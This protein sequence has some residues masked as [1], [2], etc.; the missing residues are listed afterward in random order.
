MTE[1]MAKKAMTDAHNGLLRY[2]QE[3]EQSA[4]KRQSKNYVLY[5]YT[6]AE[7]LKGIVENKELWATSAYYLNDSTEIIYGYRLLDE[8]VA[9]WVEKVNPP[10]DSISRGLAFSMQRQFGH[11][12]L[13]RNIITPIYLICFCEEDNLLSQWRAYGQSG[14]Y[15]IGFRVPSEGIVYGLR[16]EPPV[17]TA[18]CVKVE[19]DRSEQLRRIL[20]I[21]DFVM[22]VLDEPLVTDAIRSLDSLSPFGFGWLSRTISEILVDESIAFKDAAFAVEKEWRFVVRS[23]ELLKQGTDDG[24]HTKLPIRFR[25]ARGQLTPYIRLI[26]SEKSFPL[27]GDGMNLPIVSVRCGPVGD[28]VSS[29][30]AVRMLLD[31]HGHKA[32]RID[33][34]EIPLAF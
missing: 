6:T 14:G 8:G 12:L 19:Y 33:R 1:D 13:D 4:A 28:R 22:P 10:E 21:L 16:P 15:S 27:T 18:R 20:E 26:P 30:M 3:R 25:T 29:W 32:A 9:K 5:H 23:R 11:D 34:S 17:Y 7:G 24:D 31:G 2:H